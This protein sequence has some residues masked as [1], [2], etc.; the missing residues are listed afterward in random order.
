M[1][2]QISVVSGFLGAGKTTF[3]NKILPNMEGKVALI[4]NEFGDAGLDGD[5]LPRELPVVEI[6]AG[7]ICCSVAGDFERAIKELVL[8]YHPQHI[9]IEPSGV[10][11]L[12]DIVKVCRRIGQD[13]DLDVQI[14]HLIT[15]VDTTEFEDY[16]NNFGDFYVDQITHAQIIFLSYFRPMEEQEIRKII[17]EISTINP[18]A[19][20][21]KE[22]WYSC[23]GEELVEVLNTATGLAT[24]AKE[25]RT[26]LPAAKVFD[27]LSIGKPKAFSEGELEKVLAA[28]GGKENGRI[29]RAKGI[30]EF[31]TQRF[32]LF[33]FTP[34]HCQ[35]EYLQGDKE[36]KVV[37]IGTDLNKKAI[38]EWFGK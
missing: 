13:G 9:L 16:A 29:L 33:N 8:R 26:L 27:S 20:I 30:L 3:L 28:L 21:F 5:L 2:T 38:A 18:T 32:I 15:I 1:T 17:A 12:S 25:R 10:G 35:W 24:E 7:C 19:F 22:N 34:H 37:V 4:E 14:K 36:A 23:D 11:S 31:D 6:S